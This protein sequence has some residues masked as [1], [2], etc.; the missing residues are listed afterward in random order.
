MAYG[1]SRPTPERGA[2][3]PTL[4]LPPGRFP[5][6]TSSRPLVLPSGATLTTDIH[7]HAHTWLTGPPPPGVQPFYFSAAVERCR[8]AWSP[9]PPAATLLCSGSNPPPLNVLRPLLSWPNP[10]PNERPVPT[11]F[12]FHLYSFDV[13]HSM[14]A[15]Y[16]IPPKT[17]LCPS[18]SAPRQSTQGGSPPPPVGPGAPPLHS[19]I[20]H[21][22]IPSDASFPSACM[23]YP[24]PNQLIP[25]NPCAATQKMW[26]AITVPPSPPPLCWSTLSSCGA[27][28]PVP[29][30]LPPRQTQNY[31]HHAYHFNDSRK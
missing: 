1:G 21:C 29:P 25:P 12:M 3:R 5:A 6:S 2:R 19:A 30:P 9:L 11:I 31:M 26:H 10:T 17:K 16:A 20:T 23:K 8:R 4:A 18:G 13:C 15:E 14:R 24:A 7:T 22:S 27:I 28:R